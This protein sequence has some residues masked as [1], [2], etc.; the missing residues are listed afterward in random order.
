MGRMCDGMS[1]AC[2]PCTF[3]VNDEAEV[4]CM[5]RH[6]LGELDDARHAIKQHLRS[7]LR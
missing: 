7:T 6:R 5:P 4:E 3:C 1:D 2:E